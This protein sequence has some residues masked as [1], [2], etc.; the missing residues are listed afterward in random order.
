MPSLKTLVAVPYHGDRLTVAGAMANEE[1]MTQGARNLE[2]KVGCGEDGMAD[3]RQRLLHAG[4]EVSQQLRQ[5]DT[6]FRVPTGRLKL[7]EIEDLDDSAPAR[8]EL[9]AYVRPDQATSRW[10]TYFVT[11][12]LPAEVGSLVSS[13][14]ATV[15]TLVRVAK[16]RDISIWDATRIHFDTVDGLGAFIELETVIGE[17]SDDN[18]TAEHERIVAALG[19]DRWPP[20]STSYSDLL[21]A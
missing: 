20:I 14:D 2:I 21:L 1:T 11:R 5:V 4:V 16:R 6:Y 8:A 15:G 12:I 13:L 19:L 17:Q 18:A 3:I 7:R 10:S 9:I